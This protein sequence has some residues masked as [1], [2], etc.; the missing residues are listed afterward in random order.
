[1]N[2][3]E[4]QAAHS[5]NDAVVRQIHAFSGFMDDVLNNFPPYPFKLS[6]DS[7]P[8]EGPFYIDWWIQDTEGLFG[9]IHGVNET[10]NKED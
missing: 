1:M 8:D 4:T 9:K 7:R 5:F 6:S 2:S 10:S 3:I